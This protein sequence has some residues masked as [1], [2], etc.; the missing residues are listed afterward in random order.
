MSSRRSKLGDDAVLAVLAVDVVTVVEQGRHRAS[1]AAADVTC[2]TRGRGPNVRLHWPSAVT[3]LTLNNLAGRGENAARGLPSLFP[4]E[5]RPV[6]RRLRLRDIWMS[7]PVARVVGVR[8]IKVKYKQAAL[9]PLWLLLGPLGLL[10]AV[11][12]AF[13]GVTS[14]D[15]GGVPYVL[16][17]L[18]GLTA[19][20]YIQLTASV[21]A[22]AIV[23]NY[24]LVRRSACPRLA[25][26]NAA[27]IS[28]VPPPAIMLVLTVGGAAVAGYL[29]VQALLLPAILLWLGVLAWAIALLLAAVAVRFRD[30]V[31]VV[32]LMVQAGLFVTPVG[33][34]IAHAPPHIRTLLAL[35]PVSGV[36]ESLR[37]CLLGMQPE[38]YVIALSAGIT[39]VLVT[40]A[41]MVFGRAE[42]KF[43][44]YV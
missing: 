27:L 10:A 42:V 33:Y 34:S 28:N 11:T 23:G 39:V 29:E 43:A 18:A 31:S 16:F 44:D 12:I 6:S 14:V 25:L 3:D 32:P 19:W 5:H 26:V 41:W 24:Q 8:D 36:I 30:L 22:M 35:N 2:L 37:W 15:T 21:G 20:T 9:G 13:S 38:L 1:V 17:A 40:F 4:V 7:L